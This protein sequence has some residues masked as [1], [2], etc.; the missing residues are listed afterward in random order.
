M[1]QTTAGKWPML[2]APSCL[3][4]ASCHAAPEPFDGAAWRNDYALL[5][6]G[7]Q[8]SYANLAWY[9]S[10]Q[11]GVDLPALDRKTQ[12]ALAAA[13]RDEE[14]TTAIDGFL[15]GIPDA[16]LVAYDAATVAALM[17]MDGPSHF[18]LG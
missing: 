5:K 13:T 7:L 14:A 9:A 15:N 12:A 10:P 11:G 8:A 2:A 1:G 3:L 18:R 17:K 4:A 16:H 6:T